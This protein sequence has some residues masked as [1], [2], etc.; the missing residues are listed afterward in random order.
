MRIKVSFELETPEVIKGVI[1]QLA[2]LEDIVKG[3]TYGY[4]DNT[5]NGH[6]AIGEAI[7]Q[8]EMIV[9]ALIALIHKQ[10]GELK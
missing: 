6:E 3:E 5:D 9:A 10:E 4:L 2:F 7:A 1:S 8:I